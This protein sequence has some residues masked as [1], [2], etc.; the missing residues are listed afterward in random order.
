MGWHDREIDQVLAQIGSSRQGLSHNQARL[1]LRQALR[2]TLQTRLRRRLFN[3]ANLGLAAIALITWLNQTSPWEPSA[4][5]VLILLNIGQNWWRDQKINQLRRADQTR[6]YGKSVLVYREQAWWQIPIRELVVGDL[7][8]LGRGDRLDLDLRVISCSDQLEVNQKAL[9]G[10][11]RHTKQPQP[12]ASPLPPLAHTN[13]IYAGATVSQGQVIGV[14]VHRPP[15]RSPL[16]IA[17]KKIQPYY[18]WATVVS[19]SLSIVLGQEL[20]WATAIA[21]SLYPQHWL[22]QAQLT[23]LQANQNLAKFEILLKLPIEMLARISLLCLVLPQ[24]PRI[25]PPDSPG[26]SIQAIVPGTSD[27]IQTWAAQT[28]IPL[29]SYSD[30]P[31][32]RIRLWQIQGQTVATFSDQIEHL[33]LLHQSDLAITTQNAAPELTAAASLVLPQTNLNLIAIALLTSRS[34]WHRMHQVIWFQTFSLFALVAI[35]WLGQFSILQILWYRYLV[36]PTISWALWQESG[37]YSLMALPVSHFRHLIPRPSSLFGAIAT[38]ILPSLLLYL[39]L[40]PVHLILISFTT[41]ILSYSLGISPQNPRLKI[42]ILIIS[43]IL[44]HQIPWSQTSTTQALIAFFSG[45]APLWLQLIT[46]R[47]YQL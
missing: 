3:F 27:Q 15:W 44:W 21:L 1:R 37:K 32:E 19:F 4:C 18:Q 28:K 30:S 10:N 34:A 5:L 6:L 36:I 35:A 41:A 45:S 17:I 16:E 42:I 11:L 13:M 23:Q 25:A 33:E 40:L 39:S 38:T 20:A 47:K 7:V 22:D 9:G 14:V 29:Y 43:Y 24:P 12:L 31:L 8:S 46:R 2:Q 26:L